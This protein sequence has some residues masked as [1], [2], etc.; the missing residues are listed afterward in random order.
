M[1]IK[2]ILQLLSYDLR[3][4]IASEYNFID[5]EGLHAYCSLLLSDFN[6]NSIVGKF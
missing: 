3:Y 2:K 6:E 5:L 1:G 4:C